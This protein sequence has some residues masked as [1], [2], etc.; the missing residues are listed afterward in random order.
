VI[1]FYTLAYAVG[2]TPWERAGVAGGSALADMLE[3]VE[4]G[5]GGPGRALDL[6]CGSGMHVV[7]LATRGWTVTGV[8]LVDRAL[9]RARQRLR[10]SGVPAAVLKADVTELPERLVG[11]DYDL[12]LDL[13][14]F[15]GLADADRM[16]M[17][18]AVTRL[19]APGASLL[20]LAFG[21]PVGPPFMRQ[22]ASLGDIEGA[23]PGWVTTDVRRVPTDAD[24]L[25]RLVRGAEPTMYLL[26]CS[27]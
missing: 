10:G 14:C 19:A 22:Q 6:G 18:R 13:G 12:F 8:D 7:N 15:H 21:K 26:S 3:R 16:R 4:A 5:R 27:G 20:M 1:G 25:P 17:A 23:F 9:D 2:F 11:T 24:G